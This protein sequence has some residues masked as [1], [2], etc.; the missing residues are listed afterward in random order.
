MISN[1]DIDCAKKELQKLNKDN[2]F[3]TMFRVG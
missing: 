1:S 2:K 3:Q